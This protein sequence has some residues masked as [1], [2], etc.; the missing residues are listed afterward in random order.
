[1]ILGLGHGL[2]LLLLFS[3]PIL[4]LL[5]LLLERT[6]LG[7]LFFDPPTKRRSRVDIRQAGLDMDIPH[8]HRFAECSF[9]DIKLKVFFD[10]FL[11]RVPVRI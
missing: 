10:Y 2:F 8:R 4:L 5:L 1:M 3:I 7:F 6:L 11:L 9:C